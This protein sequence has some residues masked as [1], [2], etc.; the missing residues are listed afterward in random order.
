MNKTNISW[1][2]KFVMVKT[3]ISWA[4]Y[5]WNVVTGCSKTKY[6]GCRFCY[7]ESM[8]NRF[9]KGRKFTDVRCHP[10]K[11]NE[12]YKLKKPA[13][14]FVNSMSDLFHPDVP[15]EF[16]EDVF[17]VIFDNGAIEN[18]EPFKKNQFNQHKFLI[19]T[20]RPKRALEFMKTISVSRR[21]DY[22]N[23]W[24][25]VS[26]STQQDADEL[27]PV[28]LDIPVAHR[29]VSIEPMI[30]KIDLNL[31]TTKAESYSKNEYLEGGDYDIIEHIDSLKGIE[32]HEKRTKK[33]EIIRGN[34]KYKKQVE[35]EGLKIK[36]Y[37]ETHYQQITKIKINKLDWVICGAE[38]GR[39]MRYCNNDW[40]ES[41]VEQ[42]KN[43]DVPVFVKQIHHKLIDKPG[44]FELIKEINHFPKYLQFQQYPKEL[45]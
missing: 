39:K 31:Y 41:I 29:F 45:L 6:A 27:I 23:L 40:I 33:N 43:S 20:K 21:F 5:S 3:S 17:D 2:D 28:L 18:K 7:A 4:D 1:C 42:C 30:E 16:I 10:E 22:Q 35:I 8:A 26:I 25:G 19:L 13:K 38:S 32:H 36:D 15:F 34:P 14:I 12:P 11:L 44:K 24:L 37:Y 9:W